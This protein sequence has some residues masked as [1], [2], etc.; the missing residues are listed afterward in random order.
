MLD[1]PLL[2]GSVL[3]VPRRESSCAVVLPVRPPRPAPPRSSQASVALSLHRYGLEPSPDRS[4]S[5]A[6]SRPARMPFFV[7]PAQQDDGAV[8][9]GISEL[10]HRQQQ[11]R[12]ER[13][14]C[15]HVSS[16]AQSSTRRQIFVAKDDIDVS[17]QAG[18]LCAAHRAPFERRPRVPH[19]SSRPAMSHQ[20]HPRRDA[21]AMRDP[22]IEEQRHSRTDF[23]ADV[24]AIHMS[25]D[26][27]NAA[28][29]GISPRSSMVRYDTHR[30]E[31]R[32]AGA[33]RACVGHAS[34]QSVH[35]PH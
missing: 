29:F 35:V 25:A 2:F 23:L 18:D 14:R 33:T 4:S 34:R 15:V 1:A 16:V 24:T 30:V 8:E 9:I 26:A 31:S 28:D 22:R 17:T 21:A 19:R 20:D 6:G 12:S 5:P 7:V 10:R 32:T 3:I 13:R 27:F 11:G